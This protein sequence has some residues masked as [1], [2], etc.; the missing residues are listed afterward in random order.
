MIPQVGQHV[1]C[2]L[3]TGVMA[4]GIVEEWS[5]NEVQLRSL[6]KDSILI[7]THPNEDISLIKI[8][9]SIPKIDLPIADKIDNTTEVINSQELEFAK[10]DLE[11]KFQEAKKLSSNDPTRVKTISELRIMMAAQEKKI[12]S[13]KIQNHYIGNAS[14]VKYKNSFY[15]PCKLPKGD[16]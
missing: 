9:L 3:K 14:G 11:H 16:K 5:S 1:K 13:E 2:I 6:D 8:I 7:I 15:I 12:I 10:N 4:E